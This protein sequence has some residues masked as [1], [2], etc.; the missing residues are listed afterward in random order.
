MITSIPIKNNK[1]ILRRP[2]TCRFKPPM[3]AHITTASDDL[4][5]HALRH[6]RNDKNEKAFISAI[7]DLRLT[8]ET[9]EIN[10]DLLA[11]V[12]PYRNAIGALRTILRHPGIVDNLYSLATSKFT[13][14]MFHGAASRG[15]L[16]MLK[17]LARYI[18]VTKHDLL[19][20]KER[21]VFLAAVKGNHVEIVQWLV[22]KYTINPSD[23]HNPGIASILC[24]NIVPNGNIKMAD[25]MI[26]DMG[27]RLSRCTI[28]ALI[29]IASMNEQYAMVRYLSNLV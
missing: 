9:L 6:I 17:M 16:D 26:T 8:P 21:N 25:V 4:A 27:C 2:E 24:K 1:G 15:C 3:S 22:S 29:N 20:T 23:V 28:D 11:Q 10:A 19:E 12:I 14:Y 18:K 7:N 13:M 5:M